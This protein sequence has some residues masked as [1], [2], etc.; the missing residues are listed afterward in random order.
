[1]PRGQISGWQW[2]WSLINLV[3]KMTNMCVPLCLMRPEDYH[4]HVPTYPWKWGKSV[5]RD[6]YPA[7]GA[8]GQE[9]MVE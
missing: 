4:V 2:Q 9:T 6:G 5:T 3:R 1:M 8:K 7:S